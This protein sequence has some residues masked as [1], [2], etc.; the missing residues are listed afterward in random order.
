ALTQHPEAYTL[1]LGHMEDLTLASF[2]YL[3]VPLAL[4]GMAFLAGAISSWRGRLAGVA[5]TM[6]LF[7]HAARLALV[8]FDPYLSSRPLAEALLRLRRE[9]AGGADRAASGS[10]VDA[11]AGGKRREIRVREPVVHAGN[12]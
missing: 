2:A 6:V 8:I 9:A 5:L 7:F 3:R 4:A 10:R 1:S 12:D 11:H